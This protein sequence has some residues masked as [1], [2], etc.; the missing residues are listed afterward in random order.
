MSNTFNYASN[1]SLLEREYSRYNVSRIIEN[2]LQDLLEVE[3]PMEVQDKYFVEMNLYSLA[4][5]SVVFS[6][7]IN[8]TDDQEIIKVVTLS[9]P[10]TSVR[11]LLFIDF[12]KITIDIPDGRFEAVFNFFIPKVGNANSKPLT[13]T[14][15]SPSRTEIELQ[16]SPEYKTNESASLLT[17]FASPQINHTWVL[18]AM[19]YICNQTQ[20]LNTSIPTDQTTLSFDI[21]KEF[22]PINVVENLNNPNTSGILT[23]SVELSTQTLL[24]NT[25]NYATA[26]IETYISDNVT[27]TNTMLVEILSS[28]LNEA[29]SDYVQNIRYKLL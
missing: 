22:L 3:L 13:I 18:Q 17:N 7:T 29:Y 28:S 4:D 24:N 5:N 25:Y 23:S 9:Y 21:I 27:F 20:S 11:R 6:T 12:S 10:D 26:S 19:Q 14:K 2:P 1:V 8:P 16:L 15:I